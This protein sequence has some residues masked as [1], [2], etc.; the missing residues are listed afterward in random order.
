MLVYSRRSCFYLPER[1]TR[2]KAVNM[3]STMFWTTIKVAPSRHAIL[4][5]AIVEDRDNISTGK[6]DPSKLQQYMT[7]FSSALIT[8]ESGLQAIDRKKMACIIPQGVPLTIG[9]VHLRTDSVECF[10]LSPAGSLKTGFLKQRCIGAEF[11]N[12]RFIL[13]FRPHLL[14]S[15]AVKRE[16]IYSLYY[17]DF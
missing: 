16:A 11:K 3:I 1:A 12:T 15:K 8:R 17:K 13:P 5:Y 6:N 10:Q 7:L 9:D 4:K 2:Q 14:L